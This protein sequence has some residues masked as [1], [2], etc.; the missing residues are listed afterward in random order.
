MLYLCN[1]N[2]NKPERD[3]KIKDINKW[4]KNL[5]SYEIALI[6]PGEYEKAMESADPTV[7]INTFIKEAK[8]LW[9][10]LPDEEKME[11]YEQYK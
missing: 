11:I 4:F 10:N 5:D 7:N 2:K 6:F 9:M 1:G 3:M 8:V